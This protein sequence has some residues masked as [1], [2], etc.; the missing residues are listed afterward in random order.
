MDMPTASGLPGPA[1]EAPSR[2]SH[3]GPQS[4][5]APPHLP[6]HAR[7]IHLLYVPTLYC[8]LRCSYCY[9]G[10]QTGEADLQRDAQRAGGTLRHA[11][12]ALDAAGIVAFNVSLHGGEATTLPVPV[13]DDLFGTIR[14]YY[15]AHFDALNA[16]GHRKSTPHIKTNLYRFGPLR[17]L[18]DRHKVSVSAS[19]DLPL[20]LHA[21]H[22]VTRGGTQWLERTLEN[23]RLLAAYPHHKKLSTTI[24]SVHL[25]DLRAF[26]DDIWFLQ[27]DIGLD[28]NPFNL[29]F[30]FASDLNHASRGPQALAPASAPEQLALY[31]ALHREFMGTELEEGLRR[32]W[33]DEFK[34]SYCTNAVNCGERFYLLQ[35]DGEVYSCVR[36]QGIAEF[37]YGNVYT[38]PI[39]TILANGARR[40]GAIHQGQGFDAGCR[41]CAHLERCNSGCAVVKFQRSSGRSYTCE[42]QQAIYRD[43][44]L[45]FPPAAPEAQRRYARWYAQRMHPALAFTQ[46]PAP[47]AAP[48]AAHAAATDGTDATTAATA[49]PGG[50]TAD[51]GAPPSEDPAAPLLPRE[52]AETRHALRALIAADPVLQVLYSD[53]IFVLQ[54]GEQMLPLASQ[55]LKPHA[56]WYTLGRA[57]RLLLHVRRAAFRAN[58]AET[59]RNT[60]T[61]QMLRDTTV[62]YGDEQRPKQEHLFTYQLFAECLQPSERLGADW[63]MADL[64]EVV[65]LHRHLYRRGVRNNLFFTTHYLREYHYQ[66]QRANGFYHI[67]ALNLPFQ[68]FEFFYLPQERPAS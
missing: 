21:R 11:L 68:N 51:P 13:L 50:L 52:L 53:G 9:L 35:S 31:E 10:E 42:L 39:E 28:M 18:F 14:A 1:S 15:L 4:P 62:V 49:T 59:L 24:S 56:T 47:I 46:A 65:G 67:Q 58:C 66:K 26:I 20:A 63:V 45:S 36:G 32:H 61:V 2:V 22:R 12:A 5:A 48:V 43:A 60:L 64:A 16:L 57:D 8:N 44:P 30:A 33:F 40:I 6:A 23:L 54:L 55:L 7:G 41:S 17:E 29:M 19:I 25:Q 34:P 3:T 38:D 37:R 27:R